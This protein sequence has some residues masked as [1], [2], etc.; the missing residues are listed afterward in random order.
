MF[1]RIISYVFH[2][3]LMPTIGLALILSLD[4]YLKFTIQPRTQ[5]YLLV[6]LLINTF[7]FPGF[8]LLLLKARGVIG[9]VHLTDR[10]DRVVPFGIALIFYVFSYTLVQ[11]V[12]LPPI[13]SSIFLGITLSVFISF[14]LTFWVK[15]SIHMVGITGVLAA[16]IAIYLQFSANFH[17]A[18]VLTALAC[19][20]VGYARITLKAHRLSEIG[21]GTLVGFGSVFGVCMT[22][23]TI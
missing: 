12:P 19:G 2:P 7:L 22:G 4:T 23:I 14:V 20:F 9:S 8:I 18:I 5:V 17:Q 1:S 16:L 6:M 10:K 3:G 21:L 15:V 13:V 11:E